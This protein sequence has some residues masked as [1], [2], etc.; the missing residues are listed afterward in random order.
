MPAAQDPLISKAETLR[1]QVAAAEATLEILRAK[2]AKIDAELN[3][4]PAP[5]SGLD[6]LWKAALPMARTRS[7][8][9]QC[10]TQWNRIPLAERP[11]VQ[12]ASDALKTLK[13]DP[14]DRS[15]QPPNRFTVSDGRAE[16]W[17]ASLRGGGLARQVASPNR[18]YRS[19]SATRSPIMIEVRF[20][21]QETTSGMIEASAT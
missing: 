5:V 14:L 19:H 21:L 1:K 7:S 9:V 10:R 6:L 15:T 3:H 12:T 2:L 16:L 18:R 20:V 4:T 8:K 17:C 13:A 11:T